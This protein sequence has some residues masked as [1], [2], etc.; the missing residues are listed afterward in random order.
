MV[1]GEIDS[2]LLNPQHP[3]NVYEKLYRAIASIA[4]KCYSFPKIPVFDYDNWQ[5]SINILI[6]LIYQIVSG[7][8]ENYTSLDF[9][10]EM[11][12]GDDYFT[13]F[14]NDFGT[15]DILLIAQPNEE[16][17][18]TFLLDTTICSASYL[19]EV[20]TKRLT[21]T[22]RQVMNSLNDLFILKLDKNYLKPGE[23]LYIYNNKTVNL[24]SLTLSI[25]LI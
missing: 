22:G 2:A 11:I 3:Y 14:V 20:K 17:T 5:T 13:V 8:R 12:D 4:W 1:I 25:K 18:R 7:E 23:K 10:K 24:S 21:G 16:L 15:E 9:V 19:N 6:Q